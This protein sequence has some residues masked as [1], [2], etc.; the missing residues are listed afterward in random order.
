MSVSLK[1]SLVSTILALT[2]SICG[3]GWI[4]VTRLA[5]TNEFVSHISDE[6][7]PIIE[8]LGDIRYA[9]TR[10][11]V[12]TARLAQITDEGDRQKALDLANKSKADI[13]AAVAEFATE[14]SDDPPLQDTLKVF[15][16]NWPSYLA[17][18]DQIV[19]A[20]RA[21][22]LAK[23]SELLNKTS[24]P[25]FNAVIAALDK[26]VAYMDNE[27]DM[28]K[29]EAAD[30]YRQATTIVVGTIALGLFIA[31]GALALVVLTVVRPL[32][33]MTAAMRTIA[34]GKLDEVIPCADARNE[35]GEMAK[36]LVVFRDGML[37]TERMR[38]EAEITE[39]ANQQRITA[40]RHNIADAFEASMGELSEKFV[41]SSGDVAD[42]ARNLAA[43]AE[44]T[45][46]QAQAVAGAAE[47]T[48]GNVQTV[49]AGTEELAASVR[50]INIQV[51]RS[52]D[53]ARS[54]ADEASR[55]SV[56]IKS[57]SSSAESIGQ[58][59]ELIRAIAEQTNLLALNATIEAARA[60]EAGRGFAVVASEVKHLA[61]Q[62]AKA[63]DEIAKKIN[64]MQG[65]TSVTVDSISRIVSTITTI[66]E[67]TQSIASAV[68]EQGAATEEIAAN[69][70]RSAS[71][72]ADVSNN[73]AGVGT[74]AETTGVAATRLM[75][76]S[77]SMQTFSGELQREVRGFLL[78]L[79]QA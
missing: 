29:R 10:L 6:H 75:Q 20:A 55:S 16:D 21:G 40:E 23:A 28:A 4:S 14:L 27:T 38:A 39:R 78:T 44:E 47:T 62:T 24:Q 11:R 2:L 65:A 31:L 9:V 19:E 12:R 17:M 72:T 61:E 50:E 68:E 5:L 22:D 8:S 74:A 70:Q 37:E 77:G 34:A 49:A 73:I 32:R 3:L 66:Q 48:S 45:S 71:G 43:T 35:V 30:V 42:A 7:L 79:R 69:T 57:L 52:A 51:T 59:V 60:G 25:P 64:E 18:H 15:K 46:R 1:T 54:A 76:L 41:T 53:I 63:T 36:A 13:D 26:G 33:R 58:V 56:N 67:V